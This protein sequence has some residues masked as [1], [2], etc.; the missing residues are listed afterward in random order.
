VVL[1]H[2]GPNVRGGHWRWTAEV[3]YL[4]SLGYAVLEPEFRGSMGWGR[5]HFEAGWKQWGLAMHYDLCAATII[6][7]GR[8]RDSPAATSSGGSCSGCR[9]PRAVPASAT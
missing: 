5:K 3:A 6:L 8:C 7:A 9:A 1:I 2:G 4:A